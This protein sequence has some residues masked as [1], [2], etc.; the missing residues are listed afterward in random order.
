MLPRPHPSLFSFQAGGKMNAPES[1]KKALSEN[2]AV[3]TPCRAELIFYARTVRDELHS[4]EVL[5]DYTCDY[6][7]P[8][9]GHRWAEWNSRQNPYLNLFLCTNHARE[10]GLIRD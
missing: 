5:G 10:L 8:D 6:R 4:V 9:W 3:S 7:R 2:V 1:K